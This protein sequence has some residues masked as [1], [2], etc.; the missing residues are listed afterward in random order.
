MKGIWI[1]LLVGLLAA[2]GEAKR[3]RKF[4]GDFEFAEED[5]TRAVSSSSGSASSKTATGEKKRWVHDPNSDLCHPLN[6]KKKEVCLLEDSFTAVCVSKKELHKNGDVVIPK[7]KIKANGDSGKRKDGGDLGSDRRR[8]RKG[9]DDAEEDGDEEDD[10]F[11]D[12][13]DDSED[14]DDDEDDDV[15]AISRCNPCPVVKPTFLCGTD[16]RTYSSVCR[17]DYHNCIH[18]TTIRVGCKGFCPCKIPSSLNV[19]S[20]SE[21]LHRKKQ[22]ISSMVSKF[23]ATAARTKDEEGENGVATQVNSKQM[24]S[25]VSAAQQQMLKEKRERTEAA[26]EKARE[27]KRRKAAAAAAAAASADRY[28]FTPEDFK[29]ENKHYKYIKY[30]KYNKDPY[31]VTNP[32]YSEDKER[33]HGHN[34]ALDSKTNRGGISAWNKVQYVHG[35][36]SFP[37]C[38]TAALQSMGNRLLDWFSVVM[39]ETKKDGKNRRRGKGKGNSL[40]ASPSLSPMPRFPGSCKTE[41]RWMFGHLDGDSDGQLSLHELY[42]LEHDQSERCI[43]PFLDACDTDRDIFVT[44]REWCRCFDKTDRPCTAVRRRITP[45]LL[46]AYAPDCDAQ[47]YYRPTQCHAS[48][49]LCWCV[50]RHGVEFANTRTR[51]KPDCESIIGKAAGSSADREDESDD[52]DIASED[53]DDNEYGDDELEGSADRPLDF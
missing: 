22:R 28:T 33:Q 19:P 49:G 16:N 32:P 35:F 17:L 42:D 50:D 12:S 39:A 15:D 45:D 38:S 41:V 53:D 18:H 37:E 20:E 14:D 10:P 40:Q 21:L 24:A 1:I 26:K 48:V 51:G 34:E 5:D 13:E 43:K 9:E 23:R 44:P 29:Y 25:V 8:R 6:C 46:G 31:A 52:E 4:D 2:T 47:G 7:S 11:F 3:K 27:E 30:T 36:N